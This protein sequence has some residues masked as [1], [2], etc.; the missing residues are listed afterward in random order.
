VTE[1]L[2][3]LAAQNEVLEAA[4]PEERL[5]FAVRTWGQ[6][7][8]FTS[9][10]GSGSGVML[11]MWSRVAPHLPVV[12]IDTGFL[13]DET[14]AYIEKLSGQLG[15]KV[16]YARPAVAR[17]DF[18]WEHGADVMGRDPDLCCAQNKIAPLRPFTARALAWVSG[19]RRDQA[20][21]REHLPILQPTVDG[22][23][24]V[25]PLA[26]MTAEEAQAYMARHEVP[27]HPLRARRYLSVGCWPCTQPVGDGQDERAGRWAGSTKT[28]CGIHTFLRTKE[29]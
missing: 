19:V 17:D 8:L 10:F 11:H 28:E 16:E 9:S 26:T 27:E 22:P 1:A 23:I 15:L 4:T 5:S 2:L 7:L 18:L 13:F 29:A 12:V 20:R 25:H 24:K 14:H 21:T 3:D 6:R